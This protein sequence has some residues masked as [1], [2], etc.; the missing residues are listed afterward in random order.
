METAPAADE[1]F[2]RARFGDASLLGRGQFGSVYRAFDRQ[3]R[4]FVAL[5][6]LHD[7]GS[8]SARYLKR[9]FRSLSA[10]AHPNVIELLDLIVS[11][12]HACFTMELLDAEHFHLDAPPATREAARL[13]RLL[14]LVRG[15]RCIH[16]VGVVHRDLKP[17]NVLI[18]RAGRVVI[19]DCGLASRIAPSDEASP[20]A[21]TVGTP[22]YMAPELWFGA[23]PAPA[24]DIFSLGVMAYEALAGRSP[25]PTDFFATVE[26]RRAGRF[27]A[28]PADV[29]LAPP[30][31]EMI[32]RM[33]RPD[34]AERP[35]SWQI[36]A[37][38]GEHSA[39]RT[40]AR[41]LVSRVP[42]VGREADF[43]A[44]ARALAGREGPRS[45]Q[46]V[47]PSGSGK[48]R[49]LDEVLAQ[50][51]PAT[52]V[53]RTSCHPLEEILFPTLDNVID[54][55]VELVARGRAGL[56]ASLSDLDGAL[57]QMFSSL[58]PLVAPYDEPGPAPHPLELRRRAVR[59]LRA[60]L[61]RLTARGPLV[62][63]V[64]DA[65]WGDEGSWT[66]LRETLSDAD[67]GAVHLV[68]ATRDA[69]RTLLRV[70]PP[71]ALGPLPPE[72]CRAVFAH[73]VASHGEANPPSFDRV[74]EVAAGNPMALIELSSVAN[75]AALSHASHAT[76]LIDAL[77]ERIAAVTPEARR[78]LTR[79]AAA[80]EPVPVAFVTD[81][82][83]GLRCLESLRRHRL[84]DYDTAGPAQT[85]AC[86]YAWV[87]EAA[88]AVAT[89]R[90]RAEHHAHLAA[91]LIAASGAPERVVAHLRAAGEVDQLRAFALA[92]AAR[93]EGRLDFHRAAEFLEIAVR[94]GGDA[95][96]DTARR[97]ATTLEYVGRGRE[98]AELYEALARGVEGSAEGEA[99]LRRAAEQRLYAGEH[100]RGVD[101]VRRSLASQG[102][103]LVTH[104]LVAFAL[105]FLGVLRLRR[106]G[107][108]YA[109]PPGGAT[110]A[111]RTRID[112][113][114]NAVLGLS[115]TEPV[116]SAA[117]QMLHLRLAADRGTP[118]QYV[119]A[120][121]IHVVQ[122]AGY[123]YDP[124]Q[125][126]RLVRDAESMADAV[127]DD[128][129][130]GLFYLAA[131][132]AA[133]VEGRFR[134]ALHY[135]ECAAV[136][137][138]DPRSTTQWCVDS[139][140]IVRAAAR[141]HLGQWAA[142][143]ATLLDAL[144]DARD[145][146][147]L[148]L[149]SNLCVRFMPRVHLADDRADLAQ[150][151]L[152]R[153]RA[154]WDGQRYG[155]LDFFLLLERVDVLLYQGDLEGAAAL[156]APGLRKARL[157]MM[158]TLHY[159]LVL[160]QE[161][162]GRVHLARAARR[163]DARARRAAA[164][165]VKALEAA[166]SPVALAHARLQ[167]AELARLAGDRAGATRDYGAAREAFEALGVEHFRHAAAY[168]EAAPG[169]ARDA[170]V[171][172]MRAAGFANPAALLA[173]WVPC[174]ACE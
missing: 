171:A 63:V 48:T 46:L 142:M 2:D 117:L 86:S 66:L 4:A 77:T 85:V 23:G 96:R 74:C 100:E 144:A 33:L 1:G 67:A 14:Q 19:L 159:H 101:I 31:V 72:A 90:E 10:I 147:D 169:A 7:A 170:V 164:R 70:A 172:A 25:F 41:S 35:A 104:P 112:S 166:G 30:L 125:T 18:D 109:P 56:E 138:R 173:A 87:R 150:Q 29:E 15:L 32:H 99:L 94:E 53:V 82:P 16:E 13:S 50:L 22:Q 140:Q 167:R 158:L 38:L 130:M 78:L 139:L 136:R 89:E 55:I 49:L 116:S 151:S 8:D 157:A 59:A 156:L 20:D 21:P 26:A 143:R 68:I 115:M 108:A 160:A 134:E 69:V 17:A 163:G 3:R 120:L 113:L 145:R 91:R 75:A 58:R 44:L 129:A 98:A 102:V 148:F 88:L 97:L 51:P 153:G 64:D 81:D 42:F 162:M 133:W 83:A 119:Q 39:T 92:A 61:S 9:E 34:P 131:S 123:E 128:G 106:R 110:P 40:R 95:G 28:L 141:S 36:E 103:R 6:V 107:I 84:V 5:K 65:Q 43:D 27:E 135:A 118:A 124:A 11:P 137:L 62:L 60:L 114:R 154:A 155:L 93:A 126:N 165:C 132:G 24:Q 127:G 111:D 105:T 12:Q 122:R 79:T 80:G 152:D 76:W 168:G 174:A 45:I 52:T 54:Q 71:R 73:V 161:L 146:D 149:E 37:L 121:G 47:G 57:G